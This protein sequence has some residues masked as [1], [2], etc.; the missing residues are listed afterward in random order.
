MITHEK[1]DTKTLRAEISSLFFSPNESNLLTKD[2]HWDLAWP[3]PPAIGKDAVEESFLAP[4]R[5]ALSHMHRRDLIFI[6]GKN[7]LKEE[8]NWI[9]TV[10]HYVGTFTKPLWGIAPSGHLVFLRAGEFFRMEG[11]QIVE[12][13]IIFD[14]P[15]LMRQCGR[16]PL[17]SIGTELTWPAPATQDGL[18]P[19]GPYEGDAFDVVQRMIDTLHEYD[20]KTMS[21]KGQ[22]GKDG[23]WADDMFW[24]GP[25]SI[26]SNFR[27]DG[28]VQDHRRSFLDAFPDRKGGNHYCRFGDHNYAAMSGWPSMHMTWTGDYLGQSAPNQ[29]MT[30]R[31]M[32]FYRIAEGRLAENWVSLDYGDLFAQI[33]RNLIE[34]SNA[35]IT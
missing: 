29:A 33:G 17:P 35:L 12:A 9:A 32:D 14:L 2:T 10:T 13:K 28:F 21:S 24:F 22:T 5:S 7:R 15:D 4:L 31:V 16:L 19:D 18:C 34:E 8:G 30:L 27:W 26:G 25:T 3:L 23:V 1:I 20:P 11:G 6:G